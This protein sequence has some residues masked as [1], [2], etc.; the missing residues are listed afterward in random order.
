MELFHSLMIMTMIMALWCTCEP[1]NHSHNCKKGCTKV[2]IYTF[3]SAEIEEKAEMAVQDERLVAIPLNEDNFT[4][5]V[6]S[7]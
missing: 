4:S 5:H 1:C 2:S 3:C 6:I 7:L